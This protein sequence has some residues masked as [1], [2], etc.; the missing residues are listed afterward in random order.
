MLA[1]QLPQALLQRLG[2]QLLSAV[3]APL[4][5]LLVLD[6]Q[7]LLGLLLVLALQPP[8]ALPPW[9]LLVPLALQ[10]Q[11]RRSARNT[12]TATNKWLTGQRYNP[13]LVM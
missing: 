11:A 6:L 10:S 2:P 8:E 13:G 5:L 9:A 1:R 4:A 12:Y 3:L 7:L